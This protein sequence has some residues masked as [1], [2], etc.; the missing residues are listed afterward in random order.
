MRTHVGPPP[1]AALQHTRTSTC[2]CAWMLSRQHMSLS[3]CL[4]FMSLAE[5]VAASAEG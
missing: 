2:V 3:L 5:G 1:P 4:R